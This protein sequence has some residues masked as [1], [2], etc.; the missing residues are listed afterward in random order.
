L[1]DLTRRLAEWRAGDEA[2]FDAVWREVYDHLRRIAHRKLAGER[3]G[4]TLDTT[5]L[6]HETYLKLARQDRATI[7]DR[8]HLLAVAALAMRRILVNYARDRV[9]KKRGGPRVRVTFDE[10]Q[11]AGDHDIAELI[12]ID[13]LL[14]RLATL[15]DRQARVVTYRFYGGLTDAEIAEVLGV[16]LPTVRRDWRAARAWLLCELEREGSPP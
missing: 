12:A 4:H 9:A 2:A 3:S 5:A 15:D 14:D 6:V 10:G 8:A 13:D 16:S 7:E 11:A 1:A